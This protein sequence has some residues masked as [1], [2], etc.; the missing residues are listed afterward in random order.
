M[1]IKKI[2]KEVWDCLRCGHNWTPKQ[3]QK[4]GRLSDED[5]PIA[6]PKCKSPYWN[7][8]RK[9]KIKKNKMA[10]KIIK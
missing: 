8:T 2:T 3:L 7:T 10:K 9:N 6:C 1:P 5:R 4:D